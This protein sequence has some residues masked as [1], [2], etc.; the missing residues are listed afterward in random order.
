MLWKFHCCGCCSLFSS[1]PT[2]G[3]CV[4]GNVLQALS[5]WLCRCGCVSVCFERFYHYYSPFLA[6]ST[7]FRSLVSFSI[8]IIPPMVYLGKREFLLSHFR[9]GVRKGYFEV[10]QTHKSSHHHNPGRTLQRQRSNAERGGT[11]SASF[12][13]L[14]NQ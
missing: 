7:R 5:N 9:Y 4:C 14:L 2:F 10:R 13:C 8:N 1:V 11:D 12:K 6:T 3:S